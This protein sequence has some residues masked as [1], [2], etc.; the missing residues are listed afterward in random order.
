MMMHEIIIDME[1][2]FGIGATRKVSLA[3]ILFTYVLII[4]KN[5]QNYWEQQIFYKN[6]LRY[7]E[8]IS[9]FS[10]FSP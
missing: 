1:C 9:L 8:M 2:K 3:Y 5:A 4:H 6:E 10:Q 7:I